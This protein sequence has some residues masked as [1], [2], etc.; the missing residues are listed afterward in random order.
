MAETAAALAARLARSER[1]RLVAALLRVVGAGRLDLAEDCVQEAFAAAL[2]TWPRDG[3]PDNP[4]AWLMT[5]ARNRALDR[6]HRNAVLA[7]IEPKIVGWVES[8][9]APPPE[10]PF[11][12]EEFALI[13]LCCHPALEEEQRLAL[14]LKTVCGFAV[15]EIARAFLAETAA[16]A[17]R[18]VRAKAKI[19][20]LD[21]DFAAPS[22]GAIAARM[23]SVLR[24]VYLMFNEGYA[25]SG[26]DTLI[27]AAMCEEALRLAEII[28]RHPRCGSP[29]AHAL[30]ALIAFQHARAP[31]R[32]GEGDA[33]ILL[34]HQDR[35]LW[36][37][38]L[39][40][41]GFAHLRA[42]MSGEA[43]TPYHVEAGIASLHAQASRF[44]DT[45]WAQVRG[46]YDMLM[47]MSPSPVVAVN[48]AVAQ[49]MTGDL[50]GAN[51]SLA[52]AARDKRIEKYVP[53]WLTRAEIA[54]R[55][56]DANAARTAYDR[57]LALPGP[58]PGRRVIEE[59]RRA[60]R[61]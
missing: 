33:L 9:A 22:G 35:T 36:D 60:L 1:G 4:V 23:P 43:L 61:P 50:E 20:D 14:T 16:I 18:I 15:E 3:A 11:G 37:R 59:K 54:A 10:D 12:D 29:E 39:I 52:G 21:L 30:A 6:F 24:T 27:R 8:L 17:Q 13:A 45:D 49:A 42:A 19:R 38:A 51:A 7:A 58:A 46:Y 48:R 5:A 34:E 55:A 44:A 56:G 28:A 32:I 41:R 57:A 47:D 26:G 31:A 2:K 53:Y 40:A 25:A